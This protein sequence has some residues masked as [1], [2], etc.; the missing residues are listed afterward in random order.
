MNRAQRRQQ[1][2]SKQKFDNRQTFTKAEVEAMN[3]EAYK[4]GVAF[5]LMAAKHVLQ[6][7]DVRIN[8]IRTKIAEY[9]FEYF[10]NLKPF[11]KEV[12]QLVRPEGG[13][14]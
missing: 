8:R 2:R 5:T 6:L 13:N 3:E 11:D 12:E 4:Y 7:G 10:H 1:E 9:E 14:K